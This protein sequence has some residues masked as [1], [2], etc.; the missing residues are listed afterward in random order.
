MDIGILVAL[1]VGL[2]ILA[3]LSLL[4]RARRKN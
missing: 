3:Y 2:R 4:L 1:S